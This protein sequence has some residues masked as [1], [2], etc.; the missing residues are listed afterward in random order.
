LAAGKRVAVADGYPPGGC[1]GQPL[2]GFIW[3][4][5]TAMIQAGS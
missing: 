1:N 2:G 3:L 4:W 5:A